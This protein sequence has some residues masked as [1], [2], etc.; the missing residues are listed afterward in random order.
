MRSADAEPNSWRAFEGHVGYRLYRVADR[1]ADHDR[2]FS[3]ATCGRGIHRLRCRAPI[4]IE[5]S[6]ILP[7]RPDDSGESISE[8]D[9]GLVVT[10]LTFTVERPAAQPIERMSGTFSA[11]CREQSRASAVNEQSAQIHIAL[12]GDLS[13]SAL[14]CTGALV[15]SEAQPGSE[16]TARG[17]ALDIADDCTQRGAGQSADAGDLAQLLD[18]HISAS[19][20]VELLL[21]VKDLLLKQPDLL[22]HFGERC[23][24][25]Q[26]NLTLRVGERC[27]DSILGGSHAERNREAEFAQDAA[28]CYSRTAVE[29]SSIG[30][31]DDAKIESVGPR[32]F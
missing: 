30:R 18:A 19:E 31:A 15:R 12:F 10:A 6:L 8:R 2:C 20:G 25:R 17:E 21:N 1:S 16:M 28:Q 27:A 24:Q 23:A 32:R 29:C 26:W 3:N 22:Q 14:F 11:M 7:G 13:Q 9:G 4:A 5:G